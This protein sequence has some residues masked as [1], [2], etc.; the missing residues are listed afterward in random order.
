MACEG[1]GDHQ[2][3][4]QEEADVLRVGDIT[5]DR[6]ARTVEVAGA[7]VNLTPSEFK[8]LETLM[9]NPGRAFSRLELLEA[10]Q[11]IALEGVE[12]TI[13]VHIRNLR[14]KIEPDPNNPQYLGTVR[15]RG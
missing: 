9:S 15:G 1:P 5:L 2:N 11:G 10:L 8:L 3:R 13:N 4:D 6:N 14:Q 7:P 12:S